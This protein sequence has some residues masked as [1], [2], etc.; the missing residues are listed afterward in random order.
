MNGP[1]VMAPDALMFGPR[2]LGGPQLSATP[3]L[4]ETQMSIKPRFPSRLLAKYSDNP[5]RDR[6]RKILHLARGPLYLSLRG[7]RECTSHRVGP[8]ANLR[9]VAS[10][11]AYSNG[12]PSQP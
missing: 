4:V 10:R 8:A 1:S 2:F 12:L 7:S 11:S 3:L 9:T 5:S 6:R